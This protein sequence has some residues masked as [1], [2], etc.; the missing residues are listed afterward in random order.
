MTARLLPA[1]AVVLWSA[2]AAAQIDNS[3]LECGSSDTYFPRGDHWPMRGSDTPAGT[4]VTVRYQPNGADGVTSGAAQTAIQNAFNAW[5]NTTSPCSPNIDVTRGTDYP[6]RDRGDSY[7]CVSPAG[8]CTSS[9]TAGCNLQSYNNVVYFVNTTAA[10]AEI[11]D[12]Q[13]LALTTNPFIPDTGYTVTSDMEFN[14]AYFNW[15]VSGSGCSSS[16]STC[17]DVFTVAIHEAGHFLGFNHVQ[18]ADAVM[19][20]SGT[21][22]MTRTGLSSHETKGLCAIYRARAAVTNK[23]TMEQCTSTADCPSSPTHVCIKPQ[24]HGAGSTWGWCARTCATNSNCGDGFICATAD[25]GTRFC[26]P[27]VNNT[28]QVSPSAV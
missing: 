11:A 7:V 5:T 15:R 24:G 27:G 16:S 28:G 13:T 20:P 10:W 21:N 19:Y 25:V 23:D 22:T 2:A 6:S 3:A 9:C 1:L 17:Y 12:S 14:D 18:C 8:P 26:K 4:G